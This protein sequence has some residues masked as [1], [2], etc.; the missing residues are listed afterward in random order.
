MERTKVGSSSDTVQME[1]DVLVRKENTFGSS[2]DTGDSQTVQQVQRTEPQMLQTGRLPRERKPLVKYGFEDMMTYS[3]T[4][5]SGRGKMVA[6]ALTTESLDLLEGLE[7]SQQAATMPKE[8]ESLEEENQAIECKQFYKEGK[9]GSSEDR[10]Q[11][12]V[13]DRVC[14]LKKSSYGSNLDNV[15]SNLVHS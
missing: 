10:V 3:L 12:K 8:M 5:D 13:L 15:T 11:F 4:S 9:G 1:S 6:Y 7:S 2:R 14:S